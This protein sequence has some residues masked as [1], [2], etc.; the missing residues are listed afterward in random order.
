M[1]SIV[2]PTAVGKTD[3]ALA[4]ARR[5]GTEIISA[6]SRQMYRDLN[7]GTAK[8]NPEALAA[9][10]HHLIDWLDPDEALSAGR[11]Q[12]EADRILTAL[13]A[14]KNLAVMVGGSTLYMAAFWYGLNEMPEV[15]PGIRM[16]LNAELASNGLPALLAELQQVDPATYEHIDRANPARVLRALE[17]FR[18]SGQPISAFQRP[19]VPREVPWQQI[20]IGLNDDR[21]RLYARIDARVLTMVEQGLFE[22]VEGLL[23]RGLAPDCQALRSI[24][25][26]EIV[27]H[28]QGAYDRD[29]A[30]RLIQ[31]NSRR[32]AKRQ[33]T[34]YRRYDDITWFEAGH[35]AAVMEWLQGQLA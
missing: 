7:L 2:G 34:W 19:A 32:Y 28:L 5:W 15:P 20:K 10:P 13:A 30:I 17:V 8:P 11:F 18:A 3:L 16:K 29:E 22:E 1:L 4:I 25:Y 24:G 14:E 33:L 21:E 31:R 26:Q 35:T 23:A 27:A 6:D 12:R 9:V